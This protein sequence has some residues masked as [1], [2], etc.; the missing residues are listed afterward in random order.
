[1]TMKQPELGRKISDLRKAKGYTQEELVDRCNISVRTLQRIEAGEVTP[2]SYTVKTIMAALD[3]DLSMVNEDDGVRKSLAGWLKEIF[4]IDLDPDRSG[5]LLVSQLNL[6]WIFGLVY[7]ILGF[8]E[9]AADYFRMEQESV[10]LLSERLCAY[11]SPLQE[12]S[13]QDHVV[14]PDIPGY[15]Y[16]CL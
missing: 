12:L 11:G 7:F 15:T 1:M 4:L 16:N 10:L 9:G 3:Y 8:L 6:A 5:R 2:R 14:C 13:S